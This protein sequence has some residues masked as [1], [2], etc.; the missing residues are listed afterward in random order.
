MDDVVVIL[1]V[2][3]GALVLI[4]ATRWAWFGLNVMLRGNDCPCK[5]KK[6]FSLA[7]HMHSKYTLQEKTLILLTHSMYSRC[8]MI[9][10]LGN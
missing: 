10:S 8:E 5:D 6:R 4:L 7:V 3:L 9:D 2:V 1:T